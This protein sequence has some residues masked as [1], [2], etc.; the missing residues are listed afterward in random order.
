MLLTSFRNIYTCRS[1]NT[2]YKQV[3]NG[4]IKVEDAKKAIAKKIARITNSSQNYDFSAARKYHCILRKLA[5]IE[6]GTKNSNDSSVSGMING[7]SDINNGSFH[8]EPKSHKNLRGIRC[9]VSAATNGKHLTND[10]A[11]PYTDY[12]DSI[13]STLTN[14]DNNIALLSF[15]KSVHS[16]IVINHGNNKFSFISMYRDKNSNNGHEYIG[17]ASQ[18]EVKQAIANEMKINKDGLQKESL[19]YL[20]NLNVD[21]VNNYIVNNKDNYKFNIIS[22]NCSRFSA[23]ALLAGVDSHSGTFEHDRIWQMPANTLEL[24][25]EIAVRTG[26]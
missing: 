17:E 25:K 23:N 4:T 10:S 14:K 20:H 24:A 9:W 26:Q 3:L 22:N 13:M 8:Y 1:S 6:V 15:G 11:K 21:K 2:I 5:L 18:D 7:N 16:V 19:V 12:V